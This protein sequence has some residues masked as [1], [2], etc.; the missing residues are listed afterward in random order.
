MKITLRFTLASVIAILTVFTALTIFL[1]SY[2]GSRRSLMELTDNMTDEVAKGIVGKTHTLFDSAERATSELNFL[3]GSGILNATDGEALMRAAA[4]FIRDNEGFTS[5][6]IGLPSGDKYKAE[7]MPDDSISRRCYVRDAT[8][9][10][11]LWSHDNPAYND[12][13]AFRNSV[14]D[15]AKGYDARKRPW[16]K[17]AITKD[18]VAWTDMYVS[19]LRKQFVYSCVAP[20]YNAKHELLAVTSIDINVVTLSEFLGTLQILKHGKAFIL[21][22]KHQVIA[23]PIAKAEDLNQLV[24]HNPAD[25]DNPYEL[26][27]LAELPEVNIRKAVELFL[28]RQATGESTDHFEYAGAD[29]S[30]VICRML[31]FPYKNDTQFAVGIIIPESDILAGVNKRSRIIVAG[32]GGFTL[33]ALLLG[34]TISKAMSRSLTVLAGEVDKVGR[35]DLSSDVVVRSRFLEVH[36]IAA[37]VTGMRSALRSFK[38]YVPADLVLELHALRKE[39]VLEGERREVT[40]FFSDIADFTR[41]AESLS[42]EALV[43][44]LGAYF[45][46]ASTAIHDCHGTV[47]KYI[48]DCVM[49]FWG[50]PIVREDHAV[51]ACQAALD[52]QERL[53]ALRERFR[54]AGHPVFETRIGLHTGEVIVGNIG[55]PSRMNYTIVGDGVNL[56]S[57]LEGLNKTY[58]TRILVSEACF[59]RT[60]DLFVARR[61]DCVAVKGKARGVTMYELIGRAGAVDEARLTAVARYEEGL[62]AYLAR[63]FAQAE[64]LF[65][66]VF[67]AS[68]ETDLAASLMAGRC[69]AYRDQELPADWDGV[70]YAMEK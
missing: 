23:V 16:W 60:G 11:M 12:D 28:L 49:A 1:V 50:A 35:L 22:D 55:S 6:D 69:R 8:S 7:R 32:I 41:I 61:L 70:Y 18:G 4:A 10:H 29:G 17:A 20:I 31:R 13:P 30:A 2:G 3:I 43:E 68:G 52:C 59:A 48:G 5:V 19:G 57:R 62:D 40:A 67:A 14:K 45:E 56:A 36:N 26:Y 38:K 34:L 58:G 53:D 25:K 39:A 64:T 24:R 15:L 51:L 63:R 42:A 65:R 37:A 9:V 33:L 27:P 21:N 44:N 47:D 66:E 54:A 46:T